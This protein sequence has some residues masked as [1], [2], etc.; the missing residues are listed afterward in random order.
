L[1]QDNGFQY[2]IGDT[3]IFSGM[4]TRFTATKPFDCFYSPPLPAYVVVIWYTPRVE[5]RFDYIP[6]DFFIR[7]M[8]LS[9]RKSLTKERSKEIAI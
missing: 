8:R 7:E 1:A 4:K 3:P 6:I 2:K 9:K 5:K